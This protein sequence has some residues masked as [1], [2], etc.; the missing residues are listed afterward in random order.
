MAVRPLPLGLVFLDGH[1]W[2]AESHELHL[3]ANLGEYSRFLTSAG[4]TLGPIV[5]GKCDTSVLDAHFVFIA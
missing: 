4:S 2:I 1:F 3:A 5:A